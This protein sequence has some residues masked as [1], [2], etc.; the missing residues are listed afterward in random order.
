MKRKRDQDGKVLYTSD[1]SSS[2]SGDESAE[3]MFTKKQESTDN[4]GFYVER[5]CDAIKK[6][7]R[8]DGS[9]QI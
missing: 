4:D 6:S 7:A 3:E 1:E 8:M 5:L 2:D 9:K